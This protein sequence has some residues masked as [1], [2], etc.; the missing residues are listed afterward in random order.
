M[1]ITTAMAMAAGRGTRMRPLTDDRPKAMVE[2]CGRTLIDWTLDKFAEAGVAH[3]VVNV[4][5]YADMLE[6]HISG[7]DAPPV[8]ISDERETLLE[9]GGGL[10]KAAPLLGEDPVF[11]ANSDSVWIDE[12]DEPELSRL[13]AGFDPETMDFLLLFAP[14]ERQL[15]YAGKGD[16]LL[17]EDGRIERRGERESAPFAYAGVQV[18]HPRILKGEP[19]AVF[20]TNT[21]WD[22]ALKNARVF[23]LPMESYWMH[24]GDPDAK[25]LAENRLGC[26]P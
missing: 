13:A 24:V 5:H 2:V 10:V 12:G 4:H 18:M 3:A 17:H 22:K 14:V 11:V 7:R 1:K 25:T 23:G 6:A 21:L 8:T 9:T 15:G 20:S 26:D 16:F 19:E